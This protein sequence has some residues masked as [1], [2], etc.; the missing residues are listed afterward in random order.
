MSLVAWY[1]KNPD[2]AKE[3]VTQAL[4]MLET[5]QDNI[6]EITKTA[7]D[8]GIG[9]GAIV[10]GLIGAGIAGKS[11]GAKKEQEYRVL[12]GNAVQKILNEQNKKLVDMS[13]DHYTQI[14]NLEKDLKIVFSPFSVVYLL[15]GVA[16]DTISVDTM[17]SAMKQAWRNKD[18]VY[19]KNLLVNKAY[20]EAQDAEQMFIK[21]LIEQDKFLRDA[22]NKKSSN[23]EF[24]E[25]SV[26]DMH[27]FKVLDG[28]DNLHTLFKRAEESEPVA[29]YA[30]LLVDI[31]THW[32]EEVIPVELGS[33]RYAGELD[34]D[35]GMNKLAFLWFG[36]PQPEINKEVLTPNYIKKNLSV[37]YLPD[38]VLFVTDNIVISQMNVMEMNETGYEQFQNRNDKFFKQNFLKQA[39]EFGYDTEQELEILAREEDFTEEEKLRAPRRGLGALIEDLGV[40]D[41]GTPVNPTERVSEANQEKL[42][43]A[44]PGKE[45]LFRELFTKPGIHPKVY[46]LAL[47]QEFGQEWLDWDFQTLL[48]MIRDNY[49]VDPVGDSPLNKLGTIVV[50]L[51]SDSAYTGF[52]TFEKSVRSFHDKPINFEIR[53]SNISLGEIVTAIR[54][55]GDIIRDVDNNIYD[56]FSEHVLGYIVEVLHSHNY[57]AVCPKSISK[58]EDLFWKLV[59]IELLELWIATFKNTSGLTGAGADKVP[60]ETKSIQRIIREVAEEFRGK[61]DL[62]AIAAVVRDKA[63][64]AGINDA[65][66]CELIVD[67]V[68]RN[69]AVDVFWDDLEK[70]REEQIRYYLA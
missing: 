41:G 36:K 34:Y 37:V 32:D 20:L 30:N 64:N 17:N 42:A 43:A 57:R 68:S 31:A 19:F 16:I 5:E 23:T 22:I 6:I 33:Y 52:H 46:Y 40:F 29:K 25:S 66:V 60:I 3:A 45:T 2:W 15:K 50:L 62:D 7:A 18:A 67:N 47:M 10:G 9:T 12:Y 27:I 28:V 61:H 55:M 8:I 54:M 13:N 39:Q 69:L 53:E 21:R 56:N 24:D 70:R 38:R 35:L 14:A 1:D 63:Q 58:N 65:A 26:G 44:A 48:A 59:N 11:I 51:N 49:D 4:S